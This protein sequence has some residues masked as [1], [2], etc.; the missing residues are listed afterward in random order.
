MKKN[1]KAFVISS[2]ILFTVSLFLM[3]FDV[4]PTG[5][6][7]TTKK[8]GVNLGCV[9]HGSSPNDTVSVFFTGPDSVA[10]GDT[11]IF[12]V[13]V[14]HGPAVLGG[15]NA[16]SYMGEI[17]VLAGDTSVRKQDGELTHTH[18]LPF[19]SDTAKWQFEY[20]APNTPM[21]D[22]LFATG[23]ST[24]NDS[25]S[26]NDKWNWSTNR[27][28]RVYD[29]IGIINISS[30]ARDFTLSQNYP[31][32]FNPVTRIRFTVAKASDVKIVVYDILGNIAAVPVSGN[33]KQGEYEAD[34]NGS[35]MASG[36]YFYS[37]IV[38]GEKVSTKKMLMIK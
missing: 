23:N 1:L 11:A 10:A 7:G 34:F 24:N 35:N 3:S 19:T 25:T 13:G 15:F 17:N 21:I 26:D 37:L 22:T 8:G 28:V 9:C 16:A 27:L 14:S 33:M 29:A 30:I 2:S 6:V 36:V 5:Y 18:P 4:F 32:P 12:T 20:I 31:N 38:N